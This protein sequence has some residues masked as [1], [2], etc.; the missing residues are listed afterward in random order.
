M[1][2][3]DL[4]YGDAVKA[5]CNATG[6]YL[7]NG[8]VLFVSAM[9]NDICEDELARPIVKGNPHNLPLPGAKTM[10]EHLGKKTK[11]LCCGK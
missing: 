1:K 4:K 11:C 5:K 10:E 7:G 2:E 6:R 9:D 3:S 8:R